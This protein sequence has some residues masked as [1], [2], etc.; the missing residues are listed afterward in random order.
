[1]NTHDIPAIDVHAHYGDYQFGTAHEMICRFMS[2]SAEEVAQRSRASNVQWTVVSPMAGLFPRGVS[3]A[4]VEKANEQTARD[5]EAIDGLLQWVI[6]DPRRPDTYEQ[7]ERFLQTPKC[8][9]IKIHGE[10]HQYH[11]EDYGHD[12]FAFAAKH[13]AVVLAHS[14]HEHTM[15]M[16]FVPF[17]DEY[18]QARL[19]VAHMGN[20]GVAHGDPTQQI[21]AAAA[22]KHDNIYVDTS[23]SW[24]ILPHMIEW[25]VDEIGAERI[26]FGT[27]TPIY[28]TANQR[29]RI[30][31][32]QISDDAKQLILRDNAAGLLDLPA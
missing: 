8:M 32:A 18:P 27:D 13:E 7:A 25:A 6:V 4:E 28:Y 20:A 2:A 17:A 22:A 9:G 21:R 31:Y 10:E 26:L 23:S 3:I 1:M 12:L 5:V 24:S 14:G 29:A 16:R 19:I 15:P 11:I 30:D